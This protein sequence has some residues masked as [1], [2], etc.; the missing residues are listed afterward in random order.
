MIEVLTL[1]Q[2]EKLHLKCS[3][4]ANPSCQ[5]V[6]WFYNNKELSSRPCTKQF[7]AEYIIERV[8]RSH[9]GRY[10]CEVKNLLNTSFDQQYDGI[11]RVS[12]DVR[13]QCKVF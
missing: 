11:S 2:S 1:N 3:I 6:R 10:I 4:D 7:L 13:V 9:A 12:T 8:D 5:E